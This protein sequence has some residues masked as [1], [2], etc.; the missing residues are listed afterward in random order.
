MRA[1]RASFCHPIQDFCP[2]ARRS[3]IA[4]SCGAVQLLDLHLW[5][6]AASA[7]RLLAAALLTLDP[8]LH[9]VLG[10]KMMLLLALALLIAWVAPNSQQ[11]MHRYRIGL[12]SPG[13]NALARWRWPM[14]ERVLTVSQPAR[15]LSQKPRP[16]SQRARVVG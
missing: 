15:K 13:Y 7:D 9:D 4:F 3:A 1:R 8:A 12:D 6:H 16:V 2:G 14:R 10:R 11:I 5:L